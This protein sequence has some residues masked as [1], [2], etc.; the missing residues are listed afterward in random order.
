MVFFCVVV[1]F[2][3]VMAS[4]SFLFLDRYQALFLVEISSIAFLVCLIIQCGKEFLRI[5]KFE[6]TSFCAN[7]YYMILCVL[8]SFCFFYGSFLYGTIW[9]IA[10][11]YAIFPSMVVFSFITVFHQIMIIR[12]AVSGLAKDINFVKRKEEKL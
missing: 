2:S 12:K 9:R 10:K 8:V 11:G 7:Y 4:F 1:G 3:C 5:V 6:R